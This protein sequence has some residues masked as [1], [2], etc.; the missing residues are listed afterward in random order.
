MSRS[1]AMSRLLVAIQVVASAAIV[2]SARP[3]GEYPIGMTIAAVGIALGAWAIASM[4]IRSVSVMPELKSQAQ[5]TTTGPYRLVRHPMYTALLTF[6][7]G[8]AFSP[9]AI[10]KLVLWAIILAVLIAKAKIEEQQL[11]D[12]F[13]EYDR[14]AQQTKR[15]LPYIL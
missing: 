7:A 10:W 12:R 1:I 9:F 6:T 3:T 2:L 4:G 14:Y 11:R 8:L 15:F 13:P 5:L